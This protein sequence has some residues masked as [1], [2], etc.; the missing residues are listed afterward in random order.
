VTE[1]VVW[2][3]GASSG[4]G[5]AL[6]RCV[7]FPEA[8]VINISRRAVAGID[9]LQADLTSPADWE[10]IEASF[11]TELKAFDGRQAILIHNAYYADP[12]GFAGET[13]SAEVRRSVFANAAAP[14]YLG[15][16]FAKACDRR[17]DSAI[18]MMSS[19][20]A[21]IPFPGAAWYSASKA[22]IEIWIRAVAEERRRR[23]WGPWTMAV[24]PGAVDTPGL[25]R[26]TEVPP[27]DFPI[28]EA[29][30]H[31]LEASEAV[32]ADIVARQIWD[33]IEARGPSGAILKLGLD[34]DPGPNPAT[35]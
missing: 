24:R 15:H 10:R 18:V 29:A 25:R 23:G 14:L 11:A 2:I 9:N 34:A 27:D 6:A 30:K 8:R 3:T 4:L 32:P 5:A 16:A 31:A 17:F 35:S 1:S 7:P 22:G 19:T 20:A 21:A 33:A 26:T 28:A 13:D 12:F